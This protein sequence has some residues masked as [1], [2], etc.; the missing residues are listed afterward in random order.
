MTDV[1]TLTSATAGNFAVLNPLQQGAIVTANGNLNA[2]GVGV[3]YDNI[4]STIA[5][6]ATTTSGFYA[7]FTSVSNDADTVL[8]ICASNNASLGVSNGAFPFAYYADGYGLRGDGDKKNNNTNASYGVSWTNGDVISI[9]V[10][11]G[12]LYFAKNGT[13]MNSGNLSAETGFAYSG[14]TGQIVFALA[15]NGTFQFNANFGQRPFTYT[16]PSGFVRL[17]TFNLPTPTI[18]ATAST[19]ANEYFDATTYTGT[20]SSLS[21]TNSGAM[22]PDL[23]WIKIRS[24]SF[25]HTL[26]DAVRGTSKD[27]ESNTTG[28]EQTRST[29]TAFNSNGFTV[30]TDSQVNSNGNTFV[31]WQWRASNT[32]AVTNTSGSITSTVSA[33]TTSGFSIV[34]YTGNDTTGSTVGHGLG[35]VP[36]MMIVKARNDAQ[37]WTVYHRSWGN[38]GGG[39][40]NLTNAFQNQSGWWNNTTPSST[41]F[42]LGGSTGSDWYNTNKSGATYVA[43]CFAEVAGYSAFGSYTGNG[44]ADGPFVYL[45]FRPRFVIIKRTDSSDDW[46]M[47]D[48]TRSTYNVAILT[49]YANGNYAEDSNVTNRAEDFLSNGFKIRSSGVYLNASSGTYIYMA[50]AENPF[51]YANAR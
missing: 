42:T 27:L 50:F 14:I 10:K 23:V 40:L 15:I 31:A 24:Q 2:T 43:Y 35:V 19:T 16:P 32:T 36:S 45:G 38:G 29:V 37:N 34:T 49:L 8:G 48:S 3:N 6:D 22:Q 11:N 33:N 47:M 9:A 5:F 4:P 12:K 30:G 7:E 18:G 21:I 20:G 28:S 51:K 41:V 25:D 26:V 13:W 46:I 39:V 44:S 1:P 17:N